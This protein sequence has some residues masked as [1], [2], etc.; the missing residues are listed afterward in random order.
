MGAGSVNDV[1]LNEKAMRRAGG[2]STV[3]FFFWHDMC[4]G[5][6]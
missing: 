1:L 6:I 3:S 5:S 4:I 2:V